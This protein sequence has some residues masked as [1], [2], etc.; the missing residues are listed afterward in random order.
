[1]DPEYLVS[2][3]TYVQQQFQQGNHRDGQSLGFARCGHG[4]S[5]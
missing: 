1:M 3:S 4:Q 2:D 5:R